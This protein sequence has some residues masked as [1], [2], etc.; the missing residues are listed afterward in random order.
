MTVQLAS[1]LITNLIIGQAQELLVPWIMKKI[2]KWRKRK[3]NEGKVIPKYEEEGVLSPYEG[4][5]DEYAEM[6]TKSK[7]RNLLITFK[8]TKFTC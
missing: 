2:T 8:I 7:F 1:L 5:L 4:T 6:G 3:E